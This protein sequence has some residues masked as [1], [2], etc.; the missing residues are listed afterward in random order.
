MRILSMQKNFISVL[1][2]SW[3]YSVEFSKNMKS[4]KNIF[5][6]SNQRGFKMLW[7]I[8]IFIWWTSLWWENRD[9]VNWFGHIFGF[10]MWASLTFWPAIFQFLRG[11]YKLVRA[12][13]GTHRYH[14][15][16]RFSG[17]FHYDISIFQA[18]DI[19]KYISRSA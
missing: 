2:Y 4:P 6:F 17:D 5:E 13:Q 15:F 8:S 10:I 16:E 3:N 12:Q 1:N 18:P 19:S 7:I 14:L 11:Y 9:D